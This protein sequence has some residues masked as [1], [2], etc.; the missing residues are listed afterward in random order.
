MLAGGRAAEG[1]GCRLQPGYV[2]ALGLVAGA[3]ANGASGLL[4]GGFDVVVNARRG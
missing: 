4:D 3:E 1:T 2:S